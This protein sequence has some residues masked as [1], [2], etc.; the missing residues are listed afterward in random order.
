LP[1]SD[2]SLDHEKYKEAKTMETRVIHIEVRF[3][4][5]ALALLAG[6]ALMVGALAVVL[7]TADTAAADP[8]GESATAP[9]DLTGIA[10]TVGAK[11]HYQGRLE[12]ASGPVEVTFRLWEHETS[13]IGASLMWEETKTVTPTG[14]LFNTQLG[15]TNPLPP[16]D[17]D[18]RALWLGVEVAGDGEMVPRQE[19]LPVPYAMSL[20]PPA[21]ITGREDT[22]PILNVRNFG[23]GPAL[24]LRGDA[25]QNLPDNGLVKAAIF[26]GCSRP[27]A[28]RYRHF[29]NVNGAVIAVINGPIDPGTCVIDFGFDLSGRYWLA[30]ATGED[31]RLV[32]CDLGSGGTTLQCA[33]YGTDG[34]TYNGPIMV[35][36]Y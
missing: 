27:G 14:G 32:T 26:A 1:S 9:Q 8:G 6:L 22:D 18:G 5:S 28:S 15:D 10:A 36:V 2:Q 12:G 24:R 11:I 35:L 3:T 29:N 31:P 13:T 30:T 19:V 23:D 17:V 16:Y 7:W 21:R 4:P 34:V 20:R 33:R 25:E